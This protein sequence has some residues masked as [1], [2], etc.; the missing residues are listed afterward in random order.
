[1]IRRTAA[2][3]ALRAD[4]QPTSRQDAILISIRQFL[5]GANQPEKNKPQ[6]GVDLY[7]LY[8]STGNRILANYHDNKKY[9]MIKERRQVFLKD[10]MS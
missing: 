9:N 3:S 6:C 7:N 8:T 4:T 10:Q 2:A 5:I 1:V